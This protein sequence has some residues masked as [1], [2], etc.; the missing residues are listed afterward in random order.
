MSLTETG[1]PTAAVHGEPAL[2]LLDL[3]TL[4]PIGADVF[5]STCLFADG[6]YA[7]FGGQVAAQALRAAGLT[8][9]EDRVPHSL[10]GYFVAAGTAAEPVELTVERDRDGRSFSARRVVVRQAGRIMF[11]M[12]ASFQVAPTGGAGLDLTPS[13][14]VV[15]PDG[16]PGVG[17]HRMASFEG[18]FPPHDGPA[19]LPPTFWARCTTP[20]GESPILHACAL[21]YLSDFSS[22]LLGLHER[23]GSRTGPSLDHALW[24]HRPARLDDW[25]LLDMTARTVGAD[26]GWYTG[27]VHTADGML[28][29]SLAQEALFRPGRAP[30]GWFAEPPPAPSAPPAGDRE[31]PED[32]I[33]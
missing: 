20:L 19:G 7:L 25:V 28:V 14:Q 3:L 29:A 31:Q 11:S 15:E 33:R 23:T 17:L 16:L 13:P 27:T 26:R 4:E 9:P 18:R 5:R 8:V 10:H 24:F 30:E 12:G 22:G 6:P 1:G 32:R 21:T 2:D